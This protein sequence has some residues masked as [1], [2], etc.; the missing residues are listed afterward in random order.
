[1]A[2]IVT[3]AITLGAGLLGRVLPAAFVLAVIEGGECQD[4]E[5]KQGGPDGYGN[6]ELRGVISRVRHD[7]R[8]HLPPAFSVVV[9][10]GRRWST[11]GARSLTVGLGGIQ[12]GDL[13]GGGGVVEHVVKVVQMWHQVLPEGH[14]RGPVVI[15]DPRLQA[16]VQVQLIIRVILGPGHLL[17]TVGLGMDELGVL[18]HR[19]VGIP[20]DTPQKAQHD[21][22]ITNASVKFEN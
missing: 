14:F 18:W 16:N 12:W 7:K 1:M 15:A 4:V 20:G 22:Y 17:K 8:T 11:G 21:K 13:G 5:K 3:L 10:R 9:A 6:A 19:L 2:H